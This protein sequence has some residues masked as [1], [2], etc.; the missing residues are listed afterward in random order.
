MANVTHRFERSTQLP[1]GKLPPEFLD[2][3]LQKLPERGK[4]LLT[5]PGV[6][7]DAAVISFGA[8]SLVAK[9]DPVTFATDMIGWYAV[10]VNA[11]DIAATGATPKWFMPTVLLPEGTT[12]ETVEHI[13]TQIREAA[14]S[15]GV[16]LIGGHT[17]VTVGMPRPLISGAMLGEAAAS[18]TISTSG[19]KPGDHILLTKGIAVEGGSLLA[20]EFGDRTQSADITQRQLETASNYLFDPGISVLKDA[21]IALANG[22]VTAMHDPT[23]GGLASALAELRA[24]SDNGLVVEAANVTVLEE[25]REL[26]DALNVDP[27]GLIASGALLITCTPGTSQQIVDALETNGI[28]ASKIGHM[29]GPGEAAFLEKPSGKSE[30]LPVF[31][32]DEI[33]R[34]FSASG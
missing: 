24:A 21:Q 26:C 13:F 23:E 1:A 2:E 27:W 8:T 18:G 19:A 10:H 14:D 7:E 6:G 30:P 17:E 22:T 20:R 34:L 25:C 15:I 12:A 16:E 4:R 28:S 32:R 29:T 33:A 9:A 5:G 3:L 11:N 31:A